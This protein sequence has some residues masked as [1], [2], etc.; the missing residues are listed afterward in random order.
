MKTVSLSILKKDLKSRQSAYTKFLDKF[1]PFYDGIGS[2]IPSISTHTFFNFDPLLIEIGFD[3]PSIR[4]RKIS[5]MMVFL[6]SALGYDL[7]SR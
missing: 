5:F 6:S 1:I 4:M 2:D 7:M 3:I